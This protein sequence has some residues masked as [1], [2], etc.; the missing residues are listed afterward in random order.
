MTAAA[1][2]PAAGLVGPREVAFARAVAK[3]LARKFPHLADELESAAML[4]LAEAARSFDPAR[5]DEFLGFASNRVRGACLDAVRAA[6]PLGYRRRAEKPA[7]ASLSLRRHD[8]GTEWADLIPAPEDRSAAHA[9]SAEAVRSLLR[10]Y[11]PAGLALARYYAED[12]H[13]IRRVGEALGVSESRASQINARILADLREQLVSGKIDPDR[14][15]AR[16]AA[17]ADERRRLGRPPTT[18]EVQAVLDRYD[19]ALRLA[20]A[21]PAEPAPEPTPTPSP[22]PPQETT[23]ATALADP[24]MNGASKPPPAPAPTPAEE[25][26]CFQC[27][28]PKTHLRDN[29]YR[30]FRCKPGGVPKCKKCGGEKARRGQGHACLVCDDLPPPP[31]RPE[32]TPEPAPAPAPGGATPREVSAAIDR[33]VGAFPDLPAP[34]EEEEAADLAGVLAEL[35]AQRAVVAALAGLAPE[36]RRRVARWAADVMGRAS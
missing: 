11:G 31:A 16:I 35:D 5:N 22:T 17:I 28:H 19:E 33:M 36:A 3:K 10:P 12:G 2:P 8:D 18:E 20:G 29:I 14:V 30:C 13:T 26:T 9:E 4:G 23:S 15:K 6:E 24:P 7:I 27:G 21:R 34:E 1:A 25:R 32:P